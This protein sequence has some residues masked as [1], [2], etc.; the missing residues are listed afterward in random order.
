MKRTEPISIKQLIDKVMLESDT[1]EAMMQQRASY[2]WTE[3]VGAGVNR[4]TFRR[5]VD[6]GVLHVYITSASLKNDLGFLRQNILKE[7]NSRLGAEVLSD[8]VIH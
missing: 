1:R 3:V 8:I 5:Y 6:K 7:I 2:L 4:F